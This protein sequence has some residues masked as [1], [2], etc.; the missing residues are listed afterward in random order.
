MIRTLLTTGGRNYKL[1][2]KD[3]V[4]LDNLHLRFKFDILVCGD[5]TGADEGITLW[6]EDYKHWSGM[7]IAPKKVREAE[8]TK[9]G[10][11]AGPIRNSKM[12]EYAKRKSANPNNVLC[13]VFPGGKGTKDCETKA[14]NAGFQILYV[15][16]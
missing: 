12:V 8:W 16:E 10:N 1:T 15:E 14:K 4:F 7:Q 2:D 5:S 13:V 3:K 6:Y 9:Y 11:S